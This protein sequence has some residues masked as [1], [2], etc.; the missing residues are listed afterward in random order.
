MS[1]LLGLIVLIAILV[2][3]VKWCRRAARRRGRGRQVRVQRV[4]QK[5]EL[6]KRLEPPSVV[7]QIQRTILLCARGNKGIVTP[8]AV[9]ASSKVSVRLTLSGAKK[10]LDQMVR[11]GDLE[12]RI[13]QSGSPPLVYVVPEFLTD[14]S[15]KLLDDGSGNTVV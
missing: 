8:A 9:V 11:D 1:E 12:L 13:T 15:R 5:D 6:W 3:I 4:N 2:P 14:A 10:H 7:P